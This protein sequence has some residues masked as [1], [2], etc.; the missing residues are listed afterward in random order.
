MQLFSADAIVFSK[1][2][3][4]FFTPKKWKNRPQKLLIIGPDPFIPQTSPGHS[5]QPKIDFPYYEISEPDIC[6]L[7]CAKNQVCRTWFFKLGISKFKYRSIGECVQPVVSTIYLIW[8]FLCRRLWTIMKDW[9]RDFRWIIW[10]QWEMEKTKDFIVFFPGIFSILQ[11]GK[12][13]ENIIWKNQTF[14]K[15]NSLPPSKGFPWT[16]WTLWTIQNRK[17]FQWT[18][19]TA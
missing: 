11:I 2:I 8:L 16:F 5:S 10:T 15:Q 14:W 12:D 3:N 4:V 13:L 1:K 6:S 18:I 19:W 9:P 17:D 7:I